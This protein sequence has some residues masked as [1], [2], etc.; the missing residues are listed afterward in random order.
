LTGL[1]GLVAPL[2]GV[3]LYGL[4]ELAT[5]GAGVWALALPCLLTTS[6]SIGFHLMAKHTL[7]G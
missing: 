5:P 3:G 1:R 4:L 2:L 7:G 6:G